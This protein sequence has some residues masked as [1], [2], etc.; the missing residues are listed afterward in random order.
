[1]CFAYGRVDQ[2]HI[3]RQDMCI[4]HQCLFEYIDN[5][6][7]AWNKRPIYKDHH[8]NNLKNKVQE[9]SEEVNLYLVRLFERRSIGE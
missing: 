6:V 7:L 1:M 2:I 3:R 4:A 5:L 9:S 8:S